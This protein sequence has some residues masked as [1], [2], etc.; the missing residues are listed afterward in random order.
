MT[1]PLPMNSLSETVSTRNKHFL[2][3]IISNDCNVLKEIY[4]DYLPS[5]KKYILANN[6]TPSDAMDVFQDGLI[7]I[8]KKLKNGNLKLTSSFH[9]YLFSVCRFVWLNHLKK[10]RN[11]SEVH[12]ES[13]DQVKSDTN[14]EEE[15]EELEK[16]K[17][18]ESKLDELPYESKTVLKLFFNKKSIKQIAKTMGYT[19][20]YAKR[21][22]YK[23]KLQLISAIK[24]DPR[25]T[26][27][28]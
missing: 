3:G 16:R 17:L 7:V 25:F 15:Y 4:Q 6:G 24:A 19:E 22:K 21:K 28:C 2:E 12:M 5:I 8:Y 27:F 10:K 23:A 11:Q 18:F 20:G 14:I 13:A 1:T 26:T 9:T